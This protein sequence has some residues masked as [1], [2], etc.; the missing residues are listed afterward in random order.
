MIFLPIITQILT[1]GL[2]FG[3]SHWNWYYYN[4]I[5]LW[6]IPALY[7]GRNIFWIGV[8]SYVSEISTIESRTLKHGIIIATYPLSSLMGSGLVASLKI[9]IQ[10][11]YY[12]FMFL[13]PI[14]LNLLAL[15]VISLLVKDTSDSDCNR[16][17]EWQRPKYVLKEFTDLFKDKLKGSAVVLAI[18]I[19]C[20]SILVTRIGCKS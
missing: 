20:Q 9:G 12:E 14:L 2:Y 3:S 15:L 11:R 10:Y 13:V 1:D 16:D 18:L 5:Y 8:M 4:D 17:I 6:I 7:V 19:I